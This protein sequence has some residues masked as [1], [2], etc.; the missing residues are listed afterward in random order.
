MADITCAIYSNNDL[1]DYSMAE[2][3]SDT[4]PVHVVDVVFYAGKSSSLEICAS[5]DRLKM[6]VLQHMN[7]VRG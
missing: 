4:Q 3:G 2:D 6:A 7:S 1:M 5:L